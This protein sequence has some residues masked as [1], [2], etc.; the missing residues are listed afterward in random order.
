M[1]KAVKIMFN[2]RMDEFDYEET[3]KKYRY[4]AN[5]DNM[6]PVKVSDAMWANLGRPVRTRDLRVQRT[7][8][9]RV[10]PSQKIL[11]T[12]MVP[13]IYALQLFRKAAREKQHGNVVECMSLVSDGLSVIAHGRT[14][15]DRRRREALIPAGGEF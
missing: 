2:N 5:I 13:L 11:L 14:D 4:P 1:A 7:R 6:G 8:D 3:V 12:S 15:L 9:L 10:Q